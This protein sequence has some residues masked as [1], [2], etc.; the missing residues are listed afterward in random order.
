MI[1]TAE[2]SFELDPSVG[3][4]DLEV[5][6]DFR[7]GR[8]APPCSNP[9]DPAFSDTGDPA[10]WDTKLVRFKGTKM[11]LD[12]QYWQHNDKFDDAVGD[13]LIKEWESTR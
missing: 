9:D 7:P 11:K 12:K 13:A 2:L 3:P 4:V 10:E 5:E 1:I 8:P 6:A